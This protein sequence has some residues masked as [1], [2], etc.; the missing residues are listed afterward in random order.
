M[1]SSHYEPLL[2]S[3]K[4]F[5]W[6]YKSICTKIWHLSTSIFPTPTLSYSIFKTP[7]LHTEK[8]HPGTSLSSPLISQIQPMKHWE[9][10]VNM[11]CEE[12][13]HTV[14]GAIQTSLKPIRQAVKK[15]Q[16]KLSGKTCCTGRISPYSEKPQLCSQVFQLI[17]LGS[18][19]L[20]RLISLLKDQ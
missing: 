13:A 19:K 2:L 1:V 9:I 8:H 5:D 6:F 15:G 12:P 4:P 10:C 16:L 20:S 14:M 3:Q 17:E 7:M 11:H 18:H